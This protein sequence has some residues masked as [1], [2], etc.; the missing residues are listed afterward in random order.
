MASEWW[1]VKAGFM[2]TFSI[3]RPFRFSLGKDVAVDG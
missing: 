1:Q 3:S 2:L